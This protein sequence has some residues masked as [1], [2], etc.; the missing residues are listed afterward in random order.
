MAAE[1][2]RRAEAAEPVGPEPD[3][4]GSTEPIPRRLIEDRTVE[5]VEDR[6]RTRVR[7]REPP[8]GVPRDADD[9]GRLRSL[10]AHVADEQAPAVVHAGERVVEVAADVVTFAEREVANR[11]LGAGDRGKPARE[12]R[13]LQRPGH[14]FAIAEQP[15]VVDRDRGPP[16]EALDEY[17]I[18]TVVVPA[19]LGERD[20]QRPED[21]IL[22]RERDGR[23]RGQT[24]KANALERLRVR[25]RLLQHLVVDALDELGPAG[26][27]HA[28]RPGRG[29]RVEGDPLAKILGELDLARVRVREHEL[30]ELAAVEHRDAQP[31]GDPRYAE[32]REL[33]DR[34]LEVE[35]A[36]Q[37]PRR[38]GEE[39]D[40][41]ARLLGLRARDLPLL[42]DERRLEVLRA[43]TG[44]GEE[45]VAFV[46]VERM[47]LIVAQDEHGECPPADDERKRRGGD[48]VEGG[49]EGAV[50]ARRKQRIPVPP[51][52]DPNRVARSR[53]LR[54]R[55]RR[56]QRIAK[57]LVERD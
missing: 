42:E 49:L 25:S 52:L 11:E 13:P 41:L 1:R 30:S 46:L 7:G 54:A 53:R 26:A 35:R 56:R 40:A 36:R 9:R 47:Y 33:A 51:R 55:E 34:R 39:L 29:V 3:I 5:R 38:L 45:E 2:D 48:R 50:V 12:Q 44:E 6:A 27:K 16:R 8:N 15:R 14:V 21:A 28:C 37:Q 19:R 24:E 23:S 20:R 22:D 4:G 10:A 32:R 18:P 57:E 31:V 17:Q 43:Q